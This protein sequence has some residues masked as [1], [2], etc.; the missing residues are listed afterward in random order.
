MWNATLTIVGH[1]LLAA[2]VGTGGPDAP[3]PQAAPPETDAGTDSLYA[4][5]TSKGEVT[6]EV[7]PRWSGGAVVLEISAD[8]HS[9]DL[10]T[11]DLA[12]AVRLLVG[13]EEHAPSDATSLGGHHAV[14]RVTFSSIPSLPSAFDVRIRGVPDV[15]ERTLSWTPGS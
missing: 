2:T 10:S 15:P 14:A 1:L 6:V 9:V 11:L 5:R 3:L 4:T 7:R 12:D 8:T 13:G